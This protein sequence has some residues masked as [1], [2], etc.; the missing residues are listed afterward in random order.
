[1]IHIIGDIIQSVGVIIASI[2]I[3]FFPRYKIL[4]PLM[5]IFFSVIVV[6]TTIPIIKECIFTIMEAK[7]VQ[8]DYQGLRK[9]V[10]S[11]PGVKELKC[12]H[13]FCLSTDKTLIQLKIVAD[14]DDVLGKV[15]ENVLNEFECFHLNVEIQ[16][17]HI[18]YV[19]NPE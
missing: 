12:I 18:K 7:P 4:D 19:E 9:T 6:F 17:S 14:E 1:M 11:T 10:I 2:L 3:Y 8:F 16:K 15:R 13:L 5:T